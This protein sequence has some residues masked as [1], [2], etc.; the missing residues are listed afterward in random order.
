MD[1]QVRRVE[2]ANDSHRREDFIWQL[3]KSGQLTHPIAV[4]TDHEAKYLAAEIT[5]QSKETR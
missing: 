5:R 2:M 4:L 3:F 1:I